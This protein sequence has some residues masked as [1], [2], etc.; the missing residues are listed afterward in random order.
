MRVLGTQY[1]CLWKEHSNQTV[2]LSAIF[3]HTATG[4]KKKRKKKSRLAISHS[5]RA[6]RL[7]NNSTTNLIIA[8]KKNFLGNFSL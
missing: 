7:G 8:A 2:Y 3:P 6:I 1:L 4:K 5:V